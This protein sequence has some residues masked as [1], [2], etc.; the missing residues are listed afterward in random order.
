MHR[1]LGGFAAQAVGRANHLAVFH[2]AA[3]QQR[4][5]DARPMVAA[6]VLVDFRR[7]TELAPHA[8]G[9]VFVQAAIVQ[10]P[11]ERRDALVEHRHVASGVAKVVPV[12]IPKTE[13]HSNHP[14]AGLDQAA[15]DEELLE[16][17]R[18]GIAADAGVTLAV[19]LDR[20]PGFA[21]V[22]KR[23]GQ[24]ARG[25]DA[26]RLLVEGV[27]PLHQSGS[28]DVAAKLVE[29][30]QQP[31]PVLQPVETDALE[32]HV[33]LAVALGPERLVRHTTKTGLGGIVR[34]M[35][36][37]RLESDERRQRRVPRP[38]Q[39]GDHRAKGGPASRRFLRT[40]R[41]AGEA[42]VVRV[43]VARADDGADRRRPVHL[44]GDQ[45]Q[46]LADV[47]ARHSSA[48]RL[49]LAANLPRRV[50]LQV[51]HVLMR[52]AAGQVNHDD[53][54]FALAAARG[55]GGPQQLRQRQAAHAQA[56]NLE[57]VSATDAVTKSAGRISVNA[58][59]GSLLSVAARFMRSQRFTADFAHLAKRCNPLFPPLGCLVVHR[60][61]KW[62]SVPARRRAR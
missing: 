49:E 42:D 8:D 33:R 34:A 14:H 47:N 29:T 13:R 59:H 18:R 25:Q 51:V 17:A 7:A 1:P 12:P 37:P 61:A 40:E 36:H 35:L 52:R 53:G 26:E 6:A 46:H 48:D 20:A 62:H 23:L 39:L 58:Q 9:D 27:H 11:D 31:H 50:H 60:L 38:L 4:A 2:A 5:R 56:A 15:G 3:G 21:G 44:L 43:F 10:I 45:W 24:A 32:R 55:C 28:I 30:L 57:K 41:V 22:V 19:H 16:D 54:F